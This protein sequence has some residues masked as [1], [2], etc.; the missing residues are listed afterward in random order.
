MFLIRIT[1]L[2]FALG[3]MVA[4]LFAE[5]VSLLPEQSWDEDGIRTYNVQE[6]SSLYLEG[7]YKVILEQ[8]SQPGLKIKTNESNFKYIEV[9]SISHSLNLKITKK[10]FDFDELI[11]YITFKDLNKIEIDGGVSLET[12]GYL[13]FKDFELIVEGGA[14]I[15][16]N[17]KV[18]KFKVLGQGGVKLDFNGVADEL[19]ATISGAGYIDAIDLKTRKSE[20]KIEGVGAGCVDVSEELKATING[21][22]K[23][24]YKGDPIVSK[25]IEGIGLVS[26]E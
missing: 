18:D 15:D 23:I 25:N 19:T 12:L 17:L 22:G 6:F 14:C 21:I 7:T 2:I 9:E 3:L 13:N 26:N 11:L 8:G 16:M 5:P 24:R 4:K 20:I 1:S 10:H